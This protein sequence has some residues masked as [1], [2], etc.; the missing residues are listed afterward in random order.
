MKSIP[1]PHILRFTLS[2]FLIAC[3]GGAA[4]AG[5]VQASRGAQLQSSGTLAF[6]RGDFEG[7]AQS[8][9]DA[10]KAFAASGRVDEQVRA[11]SDLG[12]AYRALGRYDQAISTV[13]TALGAAD[14]AHDSPGVLLAKRTL[15]SLYTS[16]HDNA[17][18]ERYLK[19]SLTLA[20]QA[21]DDHATAS[22]LNDL[23]NL[24]T[25]QERD[26]EARD[27]Y[28]ECATLA[29]QAGEPA[30]AARADVNLAAAGEQAGSAG[31]ARLNDAA[32]GQAQ[33]LPPS[34]DKAQLLLAISQTYRR[35]AAGDAANRDA[36][37]A[38]AADAAGAA[39]PVAQQIRDSRS[40]SLALGYLGAA[41]ELQGQVDEALALT[42]RARFLAQQTQT[43]YL[44]YQWE[45]QTGR[46]L[47]AQGQP[48]EAIAAYQR[49]VEILRSVWSNCGSLPGGDTRSSFREGVGGLYY[50]LADLLLLRTDRLT[51][52]QAVQKNLVAARDT[53]ELLKS[54]ELRDYFQDPCMTAGLSKVKDIEAV[55]HKAA[56]VYTIPLPDRTE[57]LL[58]LPSG[59][60]RFTVPVGATTLIARARRLRLHLERPS[61]DQYLP[62]AQD[63]Y[64]W[65]VRPM[66]A[67][68]QGH[69]VDTLIFVPDGALRTV[70]FAALHDGKQFLI[71]KYMVAVA[72][73]V[74][75]MD[76]HPLTHT[77][78]EVFAGGISDAVQGYEALASV[79]AELH[80]ITQTYAGHELLNRQFTKP[81]VQKDLAEGDYSIV[82]IASHGEFNSNA[83][84]TYLLTYDSKLTLNDLENVV[85]PHQYQGTP[86]ELLVLSAC[87]TAAGDDRAALGLAGVAIKSGARS[88][89]ATLWSVNDEATA[90]LIAH[91]YQELRQNPTISKAGA[92]QKAQLQLMH[93]PKFQ[94]PAFWSPYLIIGNWM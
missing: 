25:S 8:W 74:T 38:R 45:W 86:V 66:E 23:G 18:A 47:R 78:V 64:N 76:P 81:E 83:A 77:K 3:C 20:R 33:G 16:T 34:Y 12:L 4:A 70:P 14:K 31:A 53:L 67:S 7:A 36:L 30:L 75:L 89:L 27:A 28:Q 40:E 93:D 84:K 90:Q 44:L 35:L 22:I 10:A 19:E 57:L 59:L 17:Q 94:H 43:P 54:A 92:L 65:L 69:G 29:R 85:R 6:R 68:L 26:T 15:G 71:E 55:L 73:G 48:D 58:G 11:L 37:L 91:F 2:V 50:Q 49:A 5:A 21:K 39:L 80:N 72:P 46:L 24:L 82:H 41:A 61:S 1:S 56:V 32:L 13:Q 88:A 9:T 87:Q 42:R 63:L 62:Y 60:E 52:P 79:P 51:Q